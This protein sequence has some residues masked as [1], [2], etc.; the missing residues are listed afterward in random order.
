MAQLI[1]KSKKPSKQRKSL[2]QA[3]DHL[4]YKHFAAPLSQE[5]RKSHGVR[6]LQLRRGDTVRVMRGDHKGFE[7]KIARVDRKNFRIYI[8]GLT[9]EKV[10]GTTVF[11]PI[12][13]SKVMIT[14]LNLDD[15]WRKRIL[16]RRKK[17]E[18]APAT[19]TE[20]VKEKPA[21]EKAAEKKHVKRQP[22]KKAEE[23]VT[24]KVEKK[25]ESEK[26]KKTTSR[27]RKK[28]EKTSEEELKSG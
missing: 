11:I 13:P 26:K 3:P 18:E 10:D 25:A 16:Q 2:F 27:T 9:R 23:K 24:K 21:E 12:H 17:P 14:K 7:G 1:T 15:K 8:E 22:S 19:I 20:E 5:L 28:K 6:N 4:R